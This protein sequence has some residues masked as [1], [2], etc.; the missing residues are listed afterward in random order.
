MNLRRELNL[1]DIT[2]FAI[3]CIVGTRWI[4]AAA[5]AGPG[6]L[7]LWVLGAMLF[8]IPLAITVGAL[9]VKYPGAGGLYV[10]TRHDFGPVARLHRLLALLVRHGLLVPSAAMFYTSAAFYTLHWSP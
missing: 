1:R 9:I 7:T 6:S 8:V 4:P 3:S 2:L 10:W 5:H